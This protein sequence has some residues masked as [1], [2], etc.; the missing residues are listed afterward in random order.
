[1]PSKRSPA[2]NAITLVVAVTLLG[3]AAYVIYNRLGT[4][5][6]IKRQHEDLRSAEAFIE[7]LKLELADNQSFNQIN[8]RA[9]PVDEPVGVVII[10]EGAVFNE[11][12]IKG[13]ETWLQSRSPPARVDYKIENVGTPAK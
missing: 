2:R 3:A 8:L 1:M 11:T 6:E 9:E 10:A 13:F 5:A 4:N 7:S 12:D